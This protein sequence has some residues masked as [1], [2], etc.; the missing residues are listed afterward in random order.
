MSVVVVASLALLADQ[1]TKA[2][3]LRALSF[4]EGIP[5]LP[6]VLHIVLHRN[7]G[8][9]FGLLSGANTLV[10]LL[11]ALVALLLLAHHRD[12][13]RA[14]RLVQVGL[15]LVLGGAAGNLLDR[16]RFG[17]VVDFLA[18]PYWPVF[19]VADVS[20]VVGGALLAFQALRHGHRSGSG[21]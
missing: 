4:G 14:D 2:W 10:G 20:V 19:N 3:V 12:R 6:P 9:A 21:S 17:Y 7:T 5:V 1:L 11:A 15:G 13:W 16:V 8:I 18:L